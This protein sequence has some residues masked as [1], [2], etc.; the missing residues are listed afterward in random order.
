MIARFWC[1]AS[2]SVS[3]VITVVG[4]I[5][6]HCPVQHRGVQHRA[7]QHCTVKHCTLR[8]SIVHYSTALYSTSLHCKALYST[9]QYCTL[10]HCSV[11]QNSVHCTAAVIIPQLIPA[12][13]Q[14]SDTAPIYTPNCALSRLISDRHI[15]N[16]LLQRQ[17]CL[18]AGLPVTLQTNSHSSSLEKFSPCQ[19]RQ[20]LSQ[21]VLTNSH[22][23]SVEKFSRRWL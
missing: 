7:V 20:I 10:Q 16:T 6:L 5:L 2:L 17:A 9:I 11:L 23:T 8:H 15:S 14:R 22:S 3:A 4:Q 18:G 1:L 12:K 21:P 19:C 13:R